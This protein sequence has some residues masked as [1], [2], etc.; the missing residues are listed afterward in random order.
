MTKADSFHRSAI[1]PVGIVRAVSMKTI[2]KRK[3]ANAATSY[4]TPDRKNPVPPK[5]PQRFPPIVGPIS[6]PISAGTESDAPI[7][8]PEPPI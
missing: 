4:E 1:D 8:A 5:R 7:T 6:F 3:I 2:W